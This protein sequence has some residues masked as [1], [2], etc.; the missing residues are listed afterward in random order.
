MKQQG[1]DWIWCGDEF[2]SE[3]KLE[4]IEDIIKLCVINTLI[5]LPTTTDSYCPLIG[6]V[7]FP[8]YVQIKKQWNK[9][10]SPVTLKDFTAMMKPRFFWSLQKNKPEI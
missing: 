6:I 7:T 2:C 9:S 4:Y 3:R 8:C 5:Y 1:D 10:F